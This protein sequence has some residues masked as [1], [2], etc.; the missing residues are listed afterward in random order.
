VSA[1]LTKC[2]WLGAR[3]ISSAEDALAEFKS[4]VHASSSVVPIQL[5]ITDEASIKN[6]HTSIKDHLTAKN[7]EG[8]DV[9]VNK[10]VLYHTTAWSC[11]RTTHPLSAGILTPDFADVFKVN[12]VGTATLTAAIRPL[13]N[14][15]GAIVNIS[16]HLGSISLYTQHELPIYPAYASSKAALNSLTVQWALQEKQAGSGIRVV[17]VCPGKYTINV[18]VGWLVQLAQ[19]V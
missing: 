7:L 1:S 11:N 2:I 8:L 17:A 19:R 9:L 18:C 6:A 16:S 3:K 14:D 13:L 10:S 5:D 12:V 4:D 15:G